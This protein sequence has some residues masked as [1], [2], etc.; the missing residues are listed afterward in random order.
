MRNPHEELPKLADRLGFANATIIDL[1]K[2]I[3]ALQLQAGK[4]AAYIAELEDENK[5]LKKKI[6]D[7]L[8]G[9]KLKKLAE[10]KLVMGYKSEIEAARKE[11]KAA[12]VARDAAFSELARLRKQMEEGVFTQNN[13]KP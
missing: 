12:R 6:E 8:A 1:R 9:M 10:E 2:Q 5:K 7:P 13:D 11:T 4:D 3:S